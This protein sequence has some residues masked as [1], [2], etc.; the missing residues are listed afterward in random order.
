MNAV[1][2]KGKD[3]AKRLDNPTVSELV[4]SL[5]NSSTPGDMVGGGS[6]M[7][8]SHSLILSA[9]ERSLTSE[10]SSLAPRPL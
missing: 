7:T 6:F 4:T 5:V 8:E 10:S 3:E 1:R 9:A 2:D